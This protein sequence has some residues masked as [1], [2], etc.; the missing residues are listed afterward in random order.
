M[1]RED[2]GGRNRESSG[3]RASG[4]GR[5]RGHLGG[6]APPRPRPPLGGI[7]ARCLGEEAVRVAARV[8]AESGA[9][10]R[11][12]DPL[13]DGPGCRAGRVLPS[14]ACRVQSGGPQ[15][16][17]PTLLLQPFASVRR[18]LLNRR[19]EPLSDP[20]GIPASRAPRVVFGDPAG[21]G[22]GQAF[23]ASSAACSR[24]SQPMARASSSKSK[25]GLWWGWSSPFSALAEPTK[26]KQPGAC[27]K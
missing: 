13:P 9:A 12:F 16:V 18:V 15:P 2:D 7:H 14:E 17:L 20:G 23:R 21:P 10:G 1:R 24:N 5:R 6:R 11:V 8:A 19:L 22:A 4:T 27:A 25:R 26:T 3:E